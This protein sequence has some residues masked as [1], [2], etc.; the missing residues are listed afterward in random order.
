[1]TLTHPEIRSLLAKHSSPEKAEIAKRFFKTGKGEYS[2]HDQFIGITVPTLR[3][4]AKDLKNISTEELQ[5]LIQSPVHEERFLSL[6]ILHFESKKNINESVAFYIKNM[7]YINNWDLVDVSASQILGPHFFN[8]NHSTLFEWGMSKS[9]WERRI[10]LL[11]T[12][13]FIRQN[14]FETTIKLVEMFL[15]D[16]EDL[17]HKASGWMLREIGKKDKKTLIEFLNQ[18]KLEMPRTMLRYSIEHFSPEDRA[19]Y[20]KRS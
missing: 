17:M 13:H 8:S 20:L 16:Q 14:F 18:F 5:F 4:I 9:L 10:A 15:N 7:K 12:H 6:V 3:Q 1:M 19:L 11:T 2:E